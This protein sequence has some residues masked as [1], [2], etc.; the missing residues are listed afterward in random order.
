M[1]N[2]TSDIDMGEEEIKRQLKL[3]DKSFVTIGIHEEAG[4]YP[5]GEGRNPPSIGQVGFW[6]EFGTENIPERSFMRSTVDENK[7]SLD[8]ETLKMKNDIL[9]GRRTVDNALSRVG[10]RIQELIRGKIEALRTP[11]NAPAT[12]KGKPETGD[13]PLIDSRLMKR[14][15]NYE[16]HIRR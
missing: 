4:K 3:L 15:V 1:I 13:N 16:V 6:N 2:T 9:S 8:R 12:I 11:P 10:F 7:A 14:S 5:S